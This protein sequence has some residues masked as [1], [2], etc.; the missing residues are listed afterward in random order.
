VLC[1]IAHLLEATQSKLKN[2]G[3]H[4]DCAAPTKLVLDFPLSYG[5]SVLE[6]FKND[7]SQLIVV[8]WN[9]SREYVEDLWDLEPSALLAGEIL[10]KQNLAQA[11]CEVIDRV[12]NGEPYRLTSGPST[13]LTHRERLVLRYVAKGLQNKSIAQRIHVEEQ[14]VKNTLRSVYRKLG[15]RNHVQAALHYWGMSHQVKR[16][17]DSRIYHPLSS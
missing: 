6:S 10:Q 13:P 1:G 3:F 5:H 9:S 8:T 11:L 4:I 12:S 7:R 16:S 17:I 15:V 2:L 14:T